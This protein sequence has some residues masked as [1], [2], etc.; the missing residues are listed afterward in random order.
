MHWRSPSAD[1]GLGVLW[2]I[3][4]D[5]ANA[6]DSPRNGVEQEVFLSCSRDYTDR[7]FNL[8]LKSKKYFESSY[9]RLLWALEGVLN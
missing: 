7:F 8:K 4:P 1:D 6:G 3:L 5:R 2:R 9:N